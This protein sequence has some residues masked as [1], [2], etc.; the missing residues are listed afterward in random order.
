MGRKLCSDT[1]PCLTV[2]A[3][4]VRLNGVL[5]PNDDIASASTGRG[6]LG[7][8]R[9]KSQR[10]YGHVGWNQGDERQV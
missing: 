4:H 8:L 7:Q 2:T 9:L 5:N 6:A 1:H 3:L 10:G